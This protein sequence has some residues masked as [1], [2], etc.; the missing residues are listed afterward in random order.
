M[1]QIINDVEK[2][3]A[4]L[5]G[6]ENLGQAMQAFDQKYG[7]GSSIGV[8]R[9][10]YKPPEAAPVVTAAPVAAP[11]VSEEVT[12]PEAEP[13]GWLMDMGKGLV[14][15]VVSAA[16]ETAQTFNST[17]TQNL[18]PAD[19]EHYGFER[20]PEQEDVLGPLDDQREVRQED[21]KDTLDK[22]TVFGSE[23]DTISGA[24]TQGLSQAI[25]GMLITGG[26][27][28]LTTWTG[29]II[30]SATA[31]YISFDPDEAN[32]VRMLDEQFGIESDITTALF[33][34][35]SE[36]ES[37]NRLHN[38]LT[39]GTL[40]VVG[41]IA[42]LGIITTFKAT[43][44]LRKAKTEV[45]ETGSVS[46]ETAQ[47]L[48]E[49]Q[50][51]ITKHAD[52]LE[53]P[54]GKLV[55]GRFVTDE[56]MA[57][58]TVTGLRD[59]E[60]EAKMTEPVAPKEG[61]SLYDTDLKPDQPPKPVDTYDSAVDLVQR[62]DTKI[63]SQPLIMKEFDIGLDEAAAIM[64]RME[65]EGVIKINHLGKVKVLPKVKQTTTPTVDDVSG[66]TT[67]PKRTA[68]DVELPAVSKLDTPEI[69]VVPKAI[70]NALAPVEVQ[71]G[72]AQ[73]LAP[74]VEAAPK[75]RQ[76]LKPLES[77]ILRETI[78]DLEINPGNIDNI[79]AILSAKLLPN[80]KY[81]QPGG[82]QAA[83]ILKATANQLEKSGA[84]KKILAVQKLQ[85]V[86]DRSV[87]LLAEEL[88]ADPDGFLVQLQEIAG[89]MDRV[90]EM[91]TAGRINLN[92]SLKELDDV[93]K[94]L[95]EQKKLGNDSGDLT[96]KYLGLID[97]HVALQDALQNIATGQGRGLNINKIMVNDELGDEALNLIDSLGGAQRASENIEKLH[98][99]LMAAKTRKAKA[100][101][102]RK[103]Q[104]PHSKIWGIA[105]EAFMGGI[106][107]GTGTH[108]LNIASAVLNLGFRPVLKSA[109]GL[110]SL[111]PKMTAQGVIDLSNTLTT[112]ADS[113][114]I[115]SIH[116]GR[117]ALKSDFTDNPLLMAGKSFLKD[118]PILDS[119]TKFGEMGPKSRSAISAPDSWVWPARYMLNGTGH[120]VNIARR[121][122]GGTDELFKQV[123]FRANI[124]SKAFMDA[125]EMGKEA[126]ADLGFKSKNAYVQEQLR[127]SVNSYERLAERYRELVKTGRGLDSDKARDEFIS[128]NLGSADTSG[129]YTGAAV[130]EARTVTFTTPLTNDNKWAKPL[131]KWANSV[132][133]LKQIAPFIRTPTNVLNENFERI[134][135][136]QN[137]MSSFK[138]QLKSD[139]PNIRAV[140]RGKFVYAYGMT[141]LAIY[142]ATEGRITGPGPSFT[143]PSERTAAK[144]WAASPDW[145]A[146]S[147]MHEDDNGNKSFT[148][149]KRLLPHAGAFTLVASIAEYLHRNEGTDP[150]DKGGLLFGS[151]ISAFASQVT[152]QSSFGGVGDFF[153]LLTDGTPKDWQ[154]F[155]E[156][157]SAAMLPL[158]ALNYQVNREAD[159]I[160]RDTTDYLELLKS[161]SNDTALSMIGA[162]RDAPFKH[163]W[164]T[165]EP[166]DTPEMA[167]GFLKQKHFEKNTKLSTVLEELR[168]LDT[169]LTGPSKRIGTRKISPAV[170]Q[171]L[172][173]LT[174]TIKDGGLTLVDSLF[175]MI[176]EQDYDRE[177]KRLAYGISSFRKDQLQSI[178]TDYKK[179]AL[180][181]MMRLYP[182][183]A[184][185]IE[186]AMEVDATLKSGEMPPAG[187]M[188][189]RSDRIELPQ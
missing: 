25:S 116:G 14:E 98:L 70:D 93:A 55:E 136:V 46:P 57:F 32:V 53:K 123:S 16:R 153:S 166:M 5:L 162:T 49:S 15:G 174:G 24:L 141:T 10:T 115:M 114:K 31:G 132:P 108:A 48:E 62:A 117:V 91:A 135:I 157:R 74:T 179:A 40:A 89:G 99:N 118:Q 183:A 112:L 19:P 127:L 66:A 65:A 87:A 140:A 23:R 8:I 18:N 39:D 29:G 27:S 147:I 173:Q 187:D 85:G 152:M 121:V 133:A 2:A 131:E 41:E 155:A 186:K 52:L 176:M 71:T 56:G 142:Y 6:Q 67:V 168:K 167:Y 45:A 43:R 151:M 158:S 159:G 60:F 100:A 50:V 105:N 156:S 59:V 33:A 35:D 3:K 150:D 128:N 106:L 104:K 137:F 11:Q 34:N 160:M 90:N 61:F 20:T 146:N 64:K 144:L 126:L 169:G 78:A 154:R 163:F 184:L 111:N 77:R 72:T 80:P 26:K 69:G 185:E 88:G 181:E 145:Q 84:S 170:H 42:I 178:V 109:G 134:P 180:E 82:A 68:A 113:L 79:D 22:V 139:D 63:V 97:H 188:E 37:V 182:E 130:A 177:G 38:A 13:D 102:L 47:A 164:L 28:A 149:L 83:A 76:P 1:T 96:I 165:G 51:E 138:R 86:E 189:T 129:K 9:N 161:R 7:E 120:V 172:N 171:R 125:S 21:I 4:W 94:Q 122:L 95:S 36:D 12:T 30:S 143:N 103:A 92:Q 101:L 54:K 124:K 73:P 175:M 58:D 75:V 148:D 44:R 81:F 119:Q 17:S 110:V 107:S